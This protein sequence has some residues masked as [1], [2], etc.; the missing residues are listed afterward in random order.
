MD[1]LKLRM[2]FLQFHARGDLHSHCKNI[3]FI[4][5][6]KKKINNLSNFFLFFFSMRIMPWNVN[7]MLCRFSKERI[8][9]LSGT[10]LA[11]SG[12]WFGPYAFALCFF[13]LCANWMDFYSLQLLR[14]SSLVQI[15]KMWRSLYGPWFYEMYDLTYKQ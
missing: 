12:S 1:T 5:W 7:I 9:A 15:T 11:Y 3:L 14:K 13:S 10:T 6:L 2:Q 4:Q 8:R